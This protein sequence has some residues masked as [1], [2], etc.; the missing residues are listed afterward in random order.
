ML[1]LAILLFNN[2]SALAGVDDEVIKKKADFI[3]EVARSINYENSIYDDYYRIGVFGKGSEIKALMKWLEEEKTG[4]NVQNKPIAIY[5]FKRVR[6]VAPVD[7]IFISG[8]SK[9]RLNDLNDKLKNTDY[10]LLTENYPF[11]SSALNFAVNESNEII[12]EIQEQVLRDKGASIKKSILRKKNRIS[13]S[14]KWRQRLSEAMEVISSQE[15]IIDENEQVISENVQTITEKEKVI[16]TQFNEL[17]FKSKTIKAQ[18]NLI[19]V[20]LV[21][22]ILILGLLFILLRINKQRRQAL[23]II[24]DKNQN[25]QDSLN[26]AKEIQNAML[27]RPAFIEKTFTKHFVLFKPKDIVSGDFYWMESA[28]DRVYFSVA[29][30]TGHGVPGALMSIICSY[31][32]TKVVKELDEREPSKILDMTA[33]L[34]K[35]YF[36]RTEET[37]YDGMDLSLICI[38][39][40]SKELIYSGAHNPLFYFKD[41]V[42]NV[43]MADKQPIGIFEKRQP[44]V[45]HKLPLNTLENIYLFSDGFADQFGGPNNKKFSKGKFKKLLLSVQDE[46]MENQL[47]IIEK[48]LDDWK[49]GVEQTDDICIAGID[50]RKLNI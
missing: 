31:A 4:I 27:P 48:A 14:R 18:R 23:V 26:Y 49:E 10:L 11:G 6:N 5:N 34:L 16:D 43:I 33:D 28:E 19:I 25:I 42:L 15:K 30:C 37:L 39:K 44:Y 45:Q 50:I 7:L 32:L 35:M 46:P 22:L 1:L 13:S 2:L 9:I 3:I 17:E 20:A 12:Y 8:D 36:S 41:G 29:D 47:R 40:K 21:S 24:E 38:D